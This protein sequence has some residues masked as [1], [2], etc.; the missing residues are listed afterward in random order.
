MLKGDEC[1]FNTAQPSSTVS[2][3]NYMAKFSKK[4][5][6]LFVSCETFSQL[7]LDAGSWI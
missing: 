1:G 7:Q 3:D 5:V 4:A 6:S 2:G